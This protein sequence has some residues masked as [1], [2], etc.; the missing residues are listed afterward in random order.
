MPV[1]PSLTHALAE[2]LVDVLWFVEG[3][4]DEQ[5]DPDDAVTVLEGVA[6]LVTQLSSDQR[7]EFID[8]LSSM[9]AEEADPSRLAF[10]ENF[11]E[12]FGF[13]EDDS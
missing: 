11:P 3:C 13:S 6:H 1:Y 10:L 4:E 5:I 2:A 7:S 12:G 8:L 9:A